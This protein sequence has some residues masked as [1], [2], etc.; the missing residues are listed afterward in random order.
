MAVQRPLDLLALAAWGVPG[1]FVLRSPG[2]LPPDGPALV[3]SPSA[4]C[5]SGGATLRALPGLRPPLSAP[6]AGLCTAA[7]RSA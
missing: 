1:P 4:T 3:V 2:A 6:D 7:W 5:A